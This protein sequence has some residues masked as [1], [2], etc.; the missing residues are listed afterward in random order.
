MALPSLIASGIVSLIFELL[1][2]IIMILI[3]VNEPKNYGDGFHILYFYLSGAS[4]I[5]KSIFILSTCY[6][7]C[8]E[9]LKLDIAFNLLVYIYT[10]I[11]MTF[12]LVLA[13]LICIDIYHFKG[14]LQYFR[15]LFMAI[16]LVYLFI[17]LSFHVI[18]ILQ[19]LSNN[20]PEKFEQTSP[21][22]YVMINNA[23]EQK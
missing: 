19:L 11:I 10:A 21:L 18:Y 3:A 17:K 14:D 1:P 7:W 15:F 9:S 23:N 4:D 6:R 2:L 20:L 22:P 16:F 5:L 12:S 8:Q 13:I